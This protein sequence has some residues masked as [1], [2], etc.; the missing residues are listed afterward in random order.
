VGLPFCNG[1]QS[2]FSPIAE[3]MVDCFMLPQ[4]ASA[5]RAGGFGG[6]IVTSGLT[7]MMRHLE[8]GR[9]GQ[10]PRRW[11]YC[12]ASLVGC[13]SLALL[14]I[15]LVADVSAGD[16][17]G[18]C[19]TFRVREQDQVWL[20]STRHLGCPSGGKYQPTFQI[21]RYEQGRWQPKTEAEFFR[22]DSD[23][24]VTPIYV[25]G[26]Q[27]DAGLASSYG[28]T[29]YF[30]FVGKLDVERAARFVIWSWP[31]DQIRGPLRDVREK[32]ARSDTDAYYLACFLGRMR[33]E[34]QVGL[35]GYSL[36]ARIAS[37]AMQLLGGGSLLAWSP[38]SAS[39][40]HVR[41]AMWA[42][43]EHNYWYQP[44]QFHGHA[45]AAVEAWFVA[46][47]CCDPILA[48][49]RMIDKCGDP[50]AVGYAG[51]YG[52]NLL[53]ADVNA[54]IEEVNVSN[55]VDGEHHWRPYLYS[56]YIQDRTRDYL[57][58]H[59]LGTSAPRESVALTAAN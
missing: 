34:V 23:Q 9:G 27:I 32:A 7:S 17:P 56:R 39:H 2:P 28:L 43:A 55:I 29:V 1:E 35:L 30:E 10:S 50:V 26:N 46:V 22:E 33:P 20:V 12:L 38:P 54:R 52:R 59:E 18:V 44:G 4:D 6:I 51:I 19:T 58:W 13:W 11:R 36:G 41:V 24:L 47:N 49:Y 8:M 25:H 45:P 42:A 14:T 21:W 48:R 3:E 53:P 5:V 15:L 31:S 57:L 16:S 37:G 40:P